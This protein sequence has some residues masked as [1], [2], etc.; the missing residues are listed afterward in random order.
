MLLAGSTVAG[1]AEEAAAG[2]KL[3][4]GPEVHGASSS[5]VLRGEEKVGVWF[6]SSDDDGMVGKGWRRRARAAAEEQRRAERK[7]K[8]TPP[9]RGSYVEDKG[10]ASTSRWRLHARRVERTW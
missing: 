1:E 6:P 10:A 7:R 4:P 9:R 8:G 2:D 3:A 5:G